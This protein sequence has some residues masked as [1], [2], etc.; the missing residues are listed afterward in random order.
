MKIVDDFYGFVMKTFNLFSGHL[1][2]MLANVKCHRKL[3]VTLVLTATL[4]Y[5]KAIYN[6]CVVIFCQHMMLFL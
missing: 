6:I 2:V 5:H 1:T 3:L 4:V